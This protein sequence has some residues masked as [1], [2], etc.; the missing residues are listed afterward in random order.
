MCITTSP[1]DMGVRG[2]DVEGA[3]AE[4]EMTAQ[5]GGTL[6][7]GRWVNVATPWKANTELKAST[8]HLLY[9]LGWSNMTTL[10]S[11]FIKEAACFI[12]A[13]DA[14]LLNPIVGDGGIQQLKPIINYCLI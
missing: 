7:R 14:I 3:A 5:G 11:R 13:E 4:S 1:V 6:L 2:W 10:S 12:H 8:Y 9:L